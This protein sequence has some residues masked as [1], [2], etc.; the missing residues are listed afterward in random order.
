MITDL[1]GY[2]AAVVGTVLMLPQV[3]SAIKT[4]SMK[5]VSMGMLVAYI[6]NCTLWDLYGILLAA[7]PMILCNSIALL[8]GVW[9]LALKKRYG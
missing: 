8:I 4:K 6:V 9:Q 1:V 3:I 2:A 7:T 5:D